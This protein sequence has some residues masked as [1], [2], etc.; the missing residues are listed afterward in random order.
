MAIQKILL[1]K[2]WN[3]FSTNL[4]NINYQKLIS[5]KKILEI[6]DFESNYNSNVLPE[7]NNLKTL[8][9]GKGYFINV[10]ENC[11]IEIEGDS[12]QIIVSESNISTTE[13]RDGWEE[14]INKNHKIIVSKDKI[15]FKEYI[16]YD[17]DLPEK[18]TWGFGLPGTD[19]YYHDKTETESIVKGIYLTAED[20]TKIINIRFPFGTSRRELFPNF[21]DLSYCYFDEKFNLIV[22]QFDNTIHDTKARYAILIR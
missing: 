12:N 16:D 15:S 2:G 4:N 21:Y 13:F 11:E 7:F 8:E 19:S 20:R 9:I 1:K 17:L 6:K 3:L 5:N 10:S 18:H 22:K 14:I